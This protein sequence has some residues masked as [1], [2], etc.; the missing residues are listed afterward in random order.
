[1]LFG[2]SNLW[3]YL[4]LHSKVINWGVMRS[5]TEVLAIDRSDIIDRCYRQRYRESQTF[6]IDSDTGSQ[7]FDIDSDTGSQTFDIDSDTGS[8]RHL[9]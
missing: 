5:V 8:H 2:S 4:N 1:M 6:A 9:I 7:T 3:Y